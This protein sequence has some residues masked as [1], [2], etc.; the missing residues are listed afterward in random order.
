MDGP[1]YCNYYSVHVSG[2]WKNYPVKQL[3]YDIL[4]FII[5]RK[6]YC[7]LAASCRYADAANGWIRSLYIDLSP[8]FQNV[9]PDGYFFEW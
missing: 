9:S 5:E 8:Q 1:E 2:A 3:F 6:L 7:T 4:L